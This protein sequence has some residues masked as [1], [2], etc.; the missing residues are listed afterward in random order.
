MN[1]E[2]RPGDVP[3]D[4]TGGF[5]TDGDGTPDTLVTDDGVDLILLTD[6][7]GDG[8]ADRALRIGP[9]GVVREADVDPDPDPEPG[10]GVVDGLFGGAE[11]GFAP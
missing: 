9:D 10:R 6:L 3:D 4:V 8:F 1:R 2:R 5:D 7:D 11:A